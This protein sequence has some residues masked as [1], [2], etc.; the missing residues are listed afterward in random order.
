MALLSVKTEKKRVRLEFKPD[1]I[2]CERCRIDSTK[3]VEKLALEFGIYKNEIIDWG[4]KT[5]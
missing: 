3:T 4:L 1:F 5:K 2:I